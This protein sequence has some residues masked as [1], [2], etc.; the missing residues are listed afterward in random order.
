MP[1]K[2]TPIKTFLNYIFCTAIKLKSTEAMTNI[3]RGA[4]NLNDDFSFQLFPKNV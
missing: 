4:L 2:F 1:H 3:H